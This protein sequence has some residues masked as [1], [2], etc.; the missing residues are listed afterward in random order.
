MKLILCGFHKKP[1]ITKLILNLY[2]REKPQNPIFASYKYTSPF[3]MTNLYSPDHSNKTG[4]LRNYDPFKQYFCLLPHNDTSRPSI[5]PKG[6]LIHY[7]DFFVDLQHS[8][9]K[10]IIYQFSNIL[11]LRLS[12]IKTNSQTF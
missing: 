4:Y 10:S 12:T 9:T 1:Q 11:S 7:D 6:D 3:T 8:H 2:S 5:V